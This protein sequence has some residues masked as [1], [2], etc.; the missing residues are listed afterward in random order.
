MILQ[1]VV[2]SIALVLSFPYKLDYLAY[3][4]PL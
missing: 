3:F 1:M 4:E 2:A